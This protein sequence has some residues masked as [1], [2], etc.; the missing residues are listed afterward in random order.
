MYRIGVIVLTELPRGVS[1]TVYQFLV[2]W[3]GVQLIIFISMLFFQKTS[4]TV[5]SVFLRLLG[6]WK[7]EIRP[8]FC[9]P[10]AGSEGE[11]LGIIPPWALLALLPFRWS[12]EMALNIKKPYY[13]LLGMYLM[14]AGLGLFHLPVLLS[15]YMVMES[16]SCLPCHWTTN[17]APCLGLKNNFLWHKFS[18]EKNLKAELVEI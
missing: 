13:Y 9:E 5:L 1:G 6:Q 12:R 4:L 11:D 18:P 16:N 8:P 17:V 14:E 7:S 2:L 10:S 15:V 3:A